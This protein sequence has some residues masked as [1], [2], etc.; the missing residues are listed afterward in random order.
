MMK[1]SNIATRVIWTK[2]EHIKDIIYWHFGWIYVEC[3]M[4]YEKEKFLAS[5]IPIL[6]FD[7]FMEDINYGDLM[8]C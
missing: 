2:I 4:L 6:Q 3:S 8:I 7:K 5:S 1:P